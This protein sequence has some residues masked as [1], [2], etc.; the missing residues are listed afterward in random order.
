M[1]KILTNSS[2]SVKAHVGILSDNAKALYANGLTQ[3]LNRAVA[4]MRQDE[5]GHALIPLYPPSGSRLRRL[6]LASSSSEV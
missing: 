6:K 3:K 1:L 2:L 4:S 5:G